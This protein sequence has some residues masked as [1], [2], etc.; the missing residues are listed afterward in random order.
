MILFAIA[1]RANAWP[2]D[3]RPTCEHCGQRVSVTEAQAMR[4]RGV[5]NERYVVWCGCSATSPSDPHHR[6]SGYGMTEAEAIADWL[7]WKR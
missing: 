2:M 7:N 3:E 1:M 6:G 5:P 4:I